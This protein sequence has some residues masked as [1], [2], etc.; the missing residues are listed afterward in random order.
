MGDHVAREKSRHSKNERTEICLFMN[1]EQHCCEYLVAN[2]QG[3]HP[4]PPM[5]KRKWFSINHK[6]YKQDHNL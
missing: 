6:Q 5:E 2:L 4:L 3:T 1:N